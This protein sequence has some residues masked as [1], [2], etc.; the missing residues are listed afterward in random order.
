MGKRGIGSGI[1]EQVK[2]SGLGGVAAFALADQIGEAA[3]RRRT[4]FGLDDAGFRITN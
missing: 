3:G 2:K 1:L 4:F